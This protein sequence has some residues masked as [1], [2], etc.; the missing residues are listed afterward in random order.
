MPNNNS[1]SVQIQSVERSMVV[2]CTSSHCYLFIY[3]HFISN[4]SKLSK[5]PVW[6]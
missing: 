6:H 4:P 2:H 3:R 5:I 1:V